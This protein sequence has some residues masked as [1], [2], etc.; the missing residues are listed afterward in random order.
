ME[1]IYPLLRMTDI[2]KTYGR[3]AVLKGVTLEVG[4]GEI[5]GLLGPN[6]A[7]KSTLIKVISGDYRAGAWGHVCER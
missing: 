5:M 6:G 7:G 1:T 2:S 4:A 3:A